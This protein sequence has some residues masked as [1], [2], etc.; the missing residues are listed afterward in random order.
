MKYWIKV[1]QAERIKGK[2]KKESIISAE[3]KGNNLLSTIGCVVTN[4]AL[5]SYLWMNIL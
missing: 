1:R 3:M 4:L 2:D 5:P